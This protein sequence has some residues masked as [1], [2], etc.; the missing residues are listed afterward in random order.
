LAAEGIAKT[1]D[2]GTAA[3]LYARALRNGQHRQYALDAI[4]KAGLV[5]TVPPSE[6]PNPAL[7]TA[8]IDSLWV[9]E[10]QL[11]EWEFC[12]DHYG[13]HHARL[14]YGSTSGGPGYGLTFGR[15]T[16]PMRELV[17][18]PKVHE[19]VLRYTNEDYGYDQDAWRR[20][21]KTRQRD[22]GVRDVP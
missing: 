20:W 3:E 13:P 9:T 16:V 8:L 12:F 15:G 7:V 21:Y 4:E 19:I 10:T 17:K 14:P 11:V 18:V 5:S 6:L 22:V 2:L 1:P